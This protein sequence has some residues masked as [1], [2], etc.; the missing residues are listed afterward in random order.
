[1]NRILLDTHCWLWFTS[2]EGRLSPG[3]RAILLDPASEL[4]L[5]AASVWEVVIKQALNKLKL[6]LPVDAYVA[7]RTEP[8]G[9]E[10]LPIEVAHTLEVGK[11]PDH[12][13]DPFDRMLIA[14]ARVEGLKL[15]TADPL[16]LRYPVDALPAGI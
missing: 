3:A 12:H 16:V 13:R 15:M 4:F 10:V 11:L 6:P 5:S 14:Q 7:T 9:I 1:M 8:L 2:D